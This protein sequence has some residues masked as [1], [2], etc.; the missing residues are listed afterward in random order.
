MKQDR[1]LD[2]R[3]MKRVPADM[4]RVRLD[5]TFEG[6]ASVFN[7]VDLGND[8]VAAGAFTGSL[9][10]RG[11]SGIRM[12]FQH[13]AAEPIGTWEKIGE[14]PQGLKVRGR[15]ALATQ[16]GR[17]VHEL[18]RAGAIDG[19]SIGFRT[20]RARQDRA[21]GARRILEADLWEISVVTF[22]MQESARIESVKRFEAGLRQGGALPSIREFERW[23]VRDAGLSRSDARRVVTKGY[24][25]CL[26]RRDAVGGSPGMPAGDLVTRIRAAASALHQGARHTNR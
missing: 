12:L 23:L 10:R 19:L 21:T 13:D 11:P 18:M 17:E 8:I 3:E 1:L 24:R 15:L 22:P 4:G 5:G 7:E 25:D 16:K 26:N 2:L 9:A 20:I 6:Y 14:T